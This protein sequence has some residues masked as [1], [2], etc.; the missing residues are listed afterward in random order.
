VGTR[1]LADAELIGV[2]G[3]KHAEFQEFVLVDI[4]VVIDS[5]FLDVREIAIVG[6]EADHEEAL[7]DHEHVVG[8]VTQAV[9]SG[10]VLPGILVECQSVVD[11][12]HA[13]AVIGMLHGGEVFDI[14]PSQFEILLVVAYPF[15]AIFA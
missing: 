15:L 2:G 12:V 3:L 5:L 9:G 14:L 6:I 10:K 8:S 11:F 13:R 4:V 7:G 1:N